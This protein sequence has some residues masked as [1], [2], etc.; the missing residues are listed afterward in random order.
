VVR[1]VHRLCMFISF[2]SYPCVEPLRHS[3]EEVLATCGGR[4]GNY[5]YILDFAGRILGEWCWVWQDK[6][7]IWTLRRVRVWVGRLHLVSIR[8]IHVELPRSYTDYQ[9]S[10]RSLV[11]G[12]SFSCKRRLGLF[13]QLSLFSCFPRSMEWTLIISCF[14]PWH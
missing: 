14:P 3:E 11:K 4:S 1:I 5:R 6:A 10:C 9:L 8:L 2:F 12:C 13:L 7:G